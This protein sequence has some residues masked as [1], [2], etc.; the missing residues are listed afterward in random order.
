[1][2]QKAAT[3]AFAKNF[4]VFKTPKAWDKEKREC[5]INEALKKGVATHRMPL[6]LFTRVK[7]EGSEAKILIGECRSI[8]DRQTCVEALR[9]DA[10]MKAEGVGVRTQQS[11]DQELRNRALIASIKH[12]TNKRGLPEGD[13]K[14]ELREQRVMHKGKEVVKVGEN[15]NLQWLDPSLKPTEEEEKSMKEGKAGV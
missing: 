1:M 10:T 13:C 4:V 8:G 6:R 9:N 5:M 11:L 14:L 7:K 2:V 3:M 12:I 15:G